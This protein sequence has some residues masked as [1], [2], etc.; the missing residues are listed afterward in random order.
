MCFIQ[1]ADRKANGYRIFSDIQLLQIKI[2]RLI[3]GHPYSNRQIRQLGYKVIEAAA[4]CEIVQCR[5]FAVEYID[6][7]REEINKAQIASDILSQWMNRGTISASKNQYNRKQ[8]ANLLG[9]SVE[10]VRNWERNGLV[11]SNLYGE[12]NERLFDDSDM[13]RLRIIYMLRQTGY[14]MSSIHRCLTMFDTG[15]RDEGLILLNKPEDEGYL[16]S[17]G[18]Q[19]LN[20]LHNLENDAVSILPLIDQLEKIKV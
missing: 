14:S 19:W 6:T 13:E 20:V 17:A 18:D 2:C 5:L 4:K 1:K 3:F 9:T 10:T 16:L 15:H 11:L 12:L 7:I 8:A